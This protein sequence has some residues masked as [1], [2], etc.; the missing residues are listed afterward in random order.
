M[1]GSKSTE[2]QIIRIVRHE[3]WMKMEDVCRRH[4]ISAATPGEPRS[5]CRGRKSCRSAP[6]SDSLR[7]ET[8]GQADRH[9]HRNHGR[10]AHRRRSDVDGRPDWRNTRRAF[11]LSTVSG[12]ASSVTA[13]FRSAP[14]LPFKT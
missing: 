14:C 12:T 3:A 1:E 6:G 10:L 4:V 5:V 13:K 11:V 7:T 9:H 2:E 8:A